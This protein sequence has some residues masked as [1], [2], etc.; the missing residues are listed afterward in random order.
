VIPKYRYIKRCCGLILL[1]ILV[2]VGK[3]AGF[4]LGGHDTSMKEGKSSRDVIGGMS[5]FVSYLLEK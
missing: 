1:L 4:R 2:V 3:P 5:R